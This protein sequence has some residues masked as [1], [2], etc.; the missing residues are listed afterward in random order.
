MQGADASNAFVEADGLKA[1]ACRRRKRKRKQKKNPYPDFVSFALLIVHE[2]KLI[3]TFSY[4]FY[5]HRLSFAFFATYIFTFFPAITTSV[6][7]N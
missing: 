6:L 4:P 2:N 5:L 7:Y 1:N 3:F